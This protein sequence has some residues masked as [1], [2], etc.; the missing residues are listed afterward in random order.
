MVKIRI[1]R[2]AVAVATVV[3][4]TTFATSASANPFFLFRLFEPNEPQGERTMPG[5]GYDAPARLKRQIVDYYTTEAPGTII[6]DTPNTYLYFIL[7]NS[8]ALRYGIGVGR[9]GFTWS[10]VHRVSQKREWPDWTP[11]GRHAAAAP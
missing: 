3:A 9:D 11:P 5:P 6:I 1:S 8:K 4:V 10:G 7:G 2:A